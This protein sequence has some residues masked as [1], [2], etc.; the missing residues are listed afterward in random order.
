MRQLL[1]RCTA[2]NL[3]GGSAHSAGLSTQQARSSKN[4]NGYID[5]APRNPDIA[6]TPETKSAI[7]PLYPQAPTRAD[8]VVG[9]ARL[10]VPQY[11][12]DGDVTQLDGTTI[13]KIEAKWVTP[14]TCNTADNDDS[15]LSLCPTD[16][17]AITAKLRL[18]F[19]MSG[20]H[21]YEPGDIEIK[22][23][24]NIFENRNGKFEGSIDLSVPEDPSTKST[25]NYRIVGDEVII[26]NTKRISAGANNYIELSYTG[27][28]P[29]NMVSGEEQHEFRAQ[30]TIESHA[31]HTL[32]KTSNPLHAVINTDERV[33]NAYKRGDVYEYLPASW[34]PYIQAPAGF[35]AKDYI[36]VDWYT[37]AYLTGNQPFQIG[38]HDPIQD[39]GILLGGTLKD[40]AGKEIYESE[41]LLEQD[42]WVE[43][44]Q[45][46][47]HH[48]FVAYP[49]QDFPVDVGK[50][51]HNTVDYT[52]TSSDTNHKTTASASAQVSWVPLDNEIAPPGFFDI[53]KWGVDEDGHTRNGTPGLI[54]DLHNERKGVV[55]DHQGYYNYA[56]NEL[57]D[58]GSTEIEY[59]IVSHNK[60][61]ALTCT[62]GTSITSPE[63]CGKRTVDFEITDHDTYFNNDFAQ[64]LTS[65][66]FEFSRLDIGDT[67]MYS[68]GKLTQ[69]GIG[70]VNDDFTQ[71]TWV[72]A[73]Q[74]GYNL[75]DTVA[76]PNYTIS[77]KR[78]TGDWFEV[79]RVTWN[80][81]TPAITTLNGASVEGTSIIFPSDVVD[82]KWNYSTNTG[83]HDLYVHPTVKLKLGEK[84]KKYVTDLMKNSDEPWAMSK[85]RVTQTVRQD[86]TTLSVDNE[87]AADILRGAAQGVWLK[88]SGKE[89]GN[90]TEAHKVSIDY[91][92]TV[93][94]QSNL[95]TQSSYRKAR[96]AG[97]I[98][99]DP[100]GTY[101]DLLPPH[102]QVD[103]AS[104]RVDGNS[105]VTG[106]T[107]HEN[108][109]NSGRT[110]LEVAISHTPNT[111]LLTS[112]EGGRGT[113]Y[114]DVRTVSY[115]AYYTWVD[116]ADCGRAL[117]NTVGYESDKE[118][119]GTITG[120]KGEPDNPSIGNN[121]YS[122]ELSEAEKQLFTDIDPSNDNPSWV[123]GTHTFNLNANVEAD[124]DLQKYVATLDKENWGSG[125]DD[126]LTVPSGGT[127]RYRLRMASAQNAKTQ[128]I[129][130]YDDLE[131]YKPAQDKDDY[132]KPQWE[133]GFVGID[134]S[135]LKALGIA[136]K[137]YYA[138][139]HVDMTQYKW[140]EDY[141][142]GQQEI[143]DL[144]GNTDRWS[145]TP[146]EDLSTVEAI[147]IDC[148]KKIDGSNF[149]LEPEQSLNVYIQMKAPSG[150]DVQNYIAQ[151]AHAYNN[152]Y[153]SSTQKLD[154]GQEAD[155]YVHKDYTKLGL[156]N[157]NVQVRKAWSDNNNQ[158]GKRPDKVVV[159]LTKDG[160]EQGA[161]IQLDATNQWTHLWEN[162][163]YANP[164]G[165]IITWS[166]I[167]Q[168]VEGYTY[169]VVSSVQTA[170][171]G[172]TEQVV[173]LTNTHVPE[174]MSV[175]G[176]KHWVETTAE[177]RPH[178]ITVELLKD[179][180]FY[181]K[182]TTNAA[183]GW[184][185]AFHDL[186][187]YRDEGTEIQWT[188]REQYVP[189]YQEKV[190]GFD[191]TNTWKPEGNIRL[192][193]TVVGRDDK[194]Q[195]Q[196]FSFRF[197]LT[198]ANGDAVTGNYEW[199]S[200]SGRSGTVAHGDTL[201]L[202]G[203]ESITIK[204]V[205]SETQYTFKETPLD[206]YKLTNSHNME[207]TVRAG[208]DI[209]AEVEAEN[210]Y[211]AQ[212][213]AQLTVQKILSGS[214]L[215][216]SQFYF[217]VVDNEG[218]VV[219]TATNNKD[220]SVNFGAFKYTE[221]DLGKHTYIIR[222]RNTGQPGYT[223]DDHKIPVTVTV[224]DNGDGTLATQVA[225]GT[226]PEAQF[227]NEYH[228]KGAVQ[229]HA[230]KTLIGDT[231][232]EGEFKFEVVDNAG[233]VVA[234]GPNSADGS[235]IMDPIEYTEKDIDYDN[236]ENNWREYTI[237]EVAD[238]SNSSIVFDEHAEKVKVKLVDNGDGTITVETHLDDGQVLEWK[239]TLGDGDLSIAKHVTGEGAEDS[240]AVFTFD[241]QLVAPDGVQ[242]PTGPVEI[243][244][245]PL[246]QTPVPQ[247]ENVV[248]HP[249]QPK[250][251]ASTARNTYAVYA[252]DPAAEGYAQWG[253]VG[254]KIEDRGEEVVLMIR[255]W[256]GNE[257]TLGAPTDVNTKPRWKDITKIESEGTIHMYWN[258]ASLFENCAKLVD[259]D[260]LSMWDASQVTTMQQM[261]Q[262][263]TSL[264]SVTALK[265]WDTSNVTAVNRM[266]RYCSN[267][268]ELDLSGW[269][270]QSLTNT[271]ELLYGCSN[272][273]S[274]DVLSWN[275][276]NVS[277]SMN[278]FYGTKNLKRIRIGLHWF[279]GPNMASRRPM[280]QSQTAKWMNETQTIEPS[281]WAEIAANW[282][283]GNYQPG[284]YDVWDSYYI[285][286]DANGGYGQ[287][288]P[289]K[290]IVTE[291][292][293]LPDNLFRRFGYEFV[294][295]TTNAD[296]T[297]TH[298]DDKATIPENTFE[299]NQ[300]VTLYAQWRSV[301]VNPTVT[302]GK[303]TVQVP[304]GQ[305]VV[306]T[307]LPGGVSYTVTEHAQPDW[308]QTGVT[309]EAGIIHPNQHPQADFTNKYVLGKTSAQLSATKLMDG[310]A[311][312]DGAF[313]FTLKDSANNVIQTVHNKQSGILFAPIQYDA[314]G[315]YTYTIEEVAGTDAAVQYDT[316]A[317]Q[318]IVTVTQNAEGKLVSS[319]AYKQVIGGQQEATSSPTFTNTSTPGAL[320]LKKVVENT[321]VDTTAFDFEVHL[322]DKDGNALSGTFSGIEFVDGTA[323]I[324]VTPKETV[325]IEGLPAGIRYTVV[326]KNQPDGY[327]TTTGTLSG[328]IEA[329]AT[330]QAQI[331]NTYTAYGDITLSAHK[332]FPHGN[333]T[334][335]RFDFIIVDQEG[336]TVA[337][338]NNDAEG[339]ITF[340]AI[341]FHAAGTYQ[342]IMREVTGDESA[343][344]YDSR[345]IPVTIT[346]TDQGAGKLKVT[347]VYSTK[348]VPLETATFTNTFKPGA[349][350]ITKRV[351]SPVTQAFT[352]TLHLTGEDGEP[353]TESYSATLE[354]K[355]MQVS[356]GSEFNLTADQTL[357]IEGLPANAT[358][359]AQE[360]VPLGFKQADGTVDTAI[361][362]P[363]TTASI[364]ILNEVNPTGELRLGATKL[365][366][367]QAPGQRRFTFQIRDEHGNIVSQA[368]NNDD[369]TIQF[370]P[371]TYEGSDAGK[372]FHY[373]IEEV[374]DE[375][376]DVDYDS[377]L[378]GFTVSVTDAGNGVLNP[379][380]RWDNAQP[381]EQSVTFKNY[382]HR[383][384]LPSTGGSGNVVTLM[385][386]GY[387][388]IAV[389]AVW[390]ILSKER[391]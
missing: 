51:V 255:P 141:Q 179:G 20:Q 235:V 284:W 172:D 23:P 311:A 125:L 96:D 173:S 337:T 330:A 135:E 7:A 379:T 197:T 126:P 33:E 111:T 251:T 138:T 223:Y 250:H 238:A 24:I 188:V 280:G 52:L 269:N 165:S 130:F 60:T 86:N 74:W 162:L 81:K 154:D 231:L 132:G 89:S 194:G 314:V 258:S 292:Y 376:E 355:T 252:G 206:G 65:D 329:H 78:D 168:E 241:V 295:W 106:V 273:A 195:N 247:R 387:A 1:Q 121:Q 80:R 363:D 272:L 77:A 229:F 240:N 58:T 207:G 291:P 156:S 303:F 236:E 299:V 245:E 356:D 147:A 216:K 12:A 278:M 94:N 153:L 333:L 119:L 391:N 322:S 92:V 182:T 275:T 390:M 239:N 70:Y 372:S 196:D 211:H 14:D 375:Q 35:H 159:Q 323:T 102:V 166:V 246:E 146:P 67:R 82:W 313:S 76:P 149:V 353:L 359:R 180:E 21:A 266:F 383:Y 114:G 142:E 256:S 103:P 308:V 351:T 199:E 19:S 110:M 328:V 59:T 281:T 161:P 186:P 345:E 8:R 347:A 348:D 72:E 167:E 30:M 307:G 176:T 354:D 98:T 95:T 71:V 160:Q 384:T 75:D 218:N 190:E 79:A 373:S 113:G 25:W 151:D 324:R 227:T 193:K 369:G 54:V 327:S 134:T 267:M 237:R 298:Y 296:G 319:V 371:I 174:V 84:T 309:G 302:D 259:I 36:Y 261:F 68:F 88:K 4:D 26:T 85:N 137:I 129:I 163:D 39:G 335:G 32:K 283:T 44:G 364:E 210:T 48:M 99:D 175:S 62:P 120:L 297:G 184:T 338:G 344:A 47:Y 289:Y 288:A 2:Q 177:H 285:N 140:S 37:Y 56:L 360:Q 350:E 374:N 145:L 170:A 274:L 87:E 213:S 16:N 368:Q 317:I 108:W 28:T 124:L 204:N 300:T 158:D 385:L 169:G 122:S 13:E 268:K 128:N 127:Y 49:R 200:T 318:A 133:G 321:D 187:K 339:N 66:D 381:Q 131:G 116:M 277:N 17:D 10:S 257:G 112:A 191:I 209:T 217:E 144:E 136:P 55:Q 61:H 362:Q 294:G 332:E 93:Y 152:V 293:Q 64:A 244:Y 198:D 320:E 29:V 287:M 378:R 11:N 306:I 316:R 69:E 388:C 312:Q 326:E 42:G 370:T 263:C 382:T 234:Q 91:E 232:R 205:P 264:I 220:G 386:L 340:D 219:R 45:Y 222:E 22:L 90:D 31:G 270:T 271:R 346:A 183:Q 5:G 226:E 315:T 243:S 221:A 325:R 230:H 228:A 377:A 265:D 201:T 164:D 115:T 123:Y 282:N 279:D 260:A 290:G 189:G 358:V 38:I 203:G 155:H 242:L 215:K 143:P 214:K 41:K 9:S 63:N 46:F 341:S 57:H 148:S 361:V 331:V 380:V 254:W 105:A 305:R 104:V 365:F 185:Y 27:L 150:K 107:I 249:V 117:S 389:A 225:Y 336:T 366:D 34:G 171:D 253:T 349:V 15:K 212:G 343:V 357:R 352:F 83:G 202:K 224:T 262:G 43:P 139:E 301:I 286:Y 6:Q 73:G 157:F 109:R 310:A 304:A 342:Y 18:D 367:D 208:E 3:T 276:A 118:S 97:Y 233:K 192:T 181:Q 50:T 100:S 248:Q 40:Q 53:D 101:Y 178:D 334:Q